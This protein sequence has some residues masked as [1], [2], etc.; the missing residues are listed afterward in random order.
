V[1]AC[2]LSVFTE[3]SSVPAT[4]GLFIQI[5]PAVHRSTDKRTRRAGDLDLTGKA[6]G[7]SVEKRSRI[8]SRLSES[9]DASK[10]ARAQRLLNHLLPGRRRRNLLLHHGFV[11]G[12]SI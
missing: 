10:K 6:A 4:F 8:R 9:I 3:A 5:A 11:P 7:D 2:S 12:T 1:S